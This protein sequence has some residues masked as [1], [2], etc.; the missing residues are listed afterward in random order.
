MAFARGSFV[1]G[2]HMCA[3]MWFLPIACGLT[4]ERAMMM[5]SCCCFTVF[6]GNI[7][8]TMEDKCDALLSCCVFLLDTSSFRG[9]GD[10]RRLVCVDV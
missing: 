5:S 2:S 6:G 4:E 8:K 3:S 1:H 7:F 9:V 10:Y